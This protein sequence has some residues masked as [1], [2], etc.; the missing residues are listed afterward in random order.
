MYTKFEH[1]VDSYFMYC[2]RNPNPYTT[3]IHRDGITCSL[4]LFMTD[5]RKLYKEQP[6]NVYL[7]LFLFSLFLLPFFLLFYC[8]LLLHALCTFMPF[9]SI[10]WLFLSFATRLHSTYYV[11]YLFTSYTLIYSA[12]VRQTTFNVYRIHFKFY[13]FDVMV[14][15][16][17]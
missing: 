14:Y 12:C 10:P 6:N 13:R 16:W 7:F 17:E 8:V 11:A 15:I 2:K 5:S 1:V 3:H 4:S 9:H